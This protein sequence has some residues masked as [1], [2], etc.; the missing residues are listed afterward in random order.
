M[1]GDALFAFIV[2]GALSPI[3]GW[4]AHLLVDWAK[5]RKAHAALEKEPLVFEGSRFERLLSREGAE[6][7]GPGRLLK[8]EPGRVL[9]GTDD[10]RRMAVSG[11]DFHA[12]R[13]Q[14]VTTDQELSAALANPHLG[15]M[16]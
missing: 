16:S 8:L 6:L 4:C 1:T 10:G 11:V 12:M 3:L 5:T 13:P 14:W 9:V 15:R 7:L 2:F